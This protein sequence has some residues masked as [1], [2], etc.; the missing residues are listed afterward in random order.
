MSLSLHRLFPTP[1]FLAAPIVGVDFSDTKIRFVRLAQGIKGLLPEQFGEAAIPEGCMQGGRVIDQARFTEFLT[2]LQK[3]HHILFARIAVPES[4]VYSF[5]LALDAVAQEDIR[6]AIE[7]VIE[8]NIPL[9]AIETVF[10]F[11]VLSKNEKNI[12]VQVAAI[13]ES[14]SETFLATFSSAGI[15][16]IGFELEGQAVARA[17]LAPQNKGSYMVVDFGAKRTGVTIITAGTAVYTSTIEFGGRN[18]IQLLVDELKVS[19]EEAELLKREYGLSS[20]GEHK[21]VFTILSSGLGMVRDEINRRYIYWHEKKN[22]LGTFPAIDTVYLCGGHSNIRGLPDYLSMVLKL[23][24]V[25][26]NPWIN[27]VSLDEEIPQMS[28]DASMSYVTAIGLSL[29]DFLYD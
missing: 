9:R 24:V 14:V 21:N 5:T 26:A 25:H 29:A 18:L 10:D 3:K 12:V 11:E 27:C 6:S 19:P 16:V 20:N 23:N 2:Q 4:Q 1:A 15:T 17:V 22:I 7:L 8:D 13:A 28:Y